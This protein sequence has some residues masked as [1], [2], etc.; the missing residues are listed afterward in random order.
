[1]HRNA[2]AG[3]KLIDPALFNDVQAH[4][5]AAPVFEG[6]VD[7]FSV[8]SGLVRKEVDEVALKL[9]APKAAYA[10]AYARYRRELAAQRGF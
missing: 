9:P 2:R 7:P 5:T 3:M 6:L 1:M 4:F 10:I 8:R